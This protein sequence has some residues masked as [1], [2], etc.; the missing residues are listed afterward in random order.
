MESLLAG[1][2]KAE[3]NTAESDA[4][5]YLRANHYTEDE[6]SGM[7]TE[8]VWNHQRDNYVRTGNGAPEVSAY[9][10][11]EDYVKAYIQYLSEQ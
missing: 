11:Y 1:T 2:E 7:L 8:D 4:V 10:T 5:S 9:P 3:E 6:I